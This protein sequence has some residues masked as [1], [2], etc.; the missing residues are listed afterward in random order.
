[1]FRWRKRKC[2]GRKLRGVYLGVIPEIKALIPHPKMSDDVIM[3]NLAEA[4]ALRLVDYEDVSFDEAARKMGTSKATVWRL[5]KSARRK[6]ARALFEG[7]ALVLTE[8]GIVER[9]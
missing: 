2:R 1:M 7:K 4:E 5:T 8:G 6:I 3:L 9:I